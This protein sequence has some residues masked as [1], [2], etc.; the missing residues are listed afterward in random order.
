MVSDNVI[1]IAAALITR[2][3]G[4]ALLVRKRGTDI[5]MQPGGKIEAGEAPVDALCRELAEELG[6]VVA[7]S[8]PV[9]LGRFAAPAANEPGHTVQ[10]EIFRL[11]V[12]ATVLPAAE[13]AEIAWVDP[14]A[15]G[16]RQIAPLSREQVLPLAVPTLAQR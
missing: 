14:R 4:Q 1:R 16:A 7:P 12:T 10:A 5:F 11:Q 15:P 9:H 13:I 3:D 2:P 8:E 6:L